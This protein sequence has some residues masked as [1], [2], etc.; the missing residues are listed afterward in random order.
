MNN[1]GKT[2]SKKLLSAA[3]A[4]LCVTAAVPAAAF[5]DD[6]PAYT[7]KDIPA[8]VHA[9]DNVKDLRS[10]FYEDMPNV[11]YV[12]VNDFYSFLL[13]RELS[14]EADGS[15]FTLTN[16]KG[17]K[18]VADADSDTLKTDDLSEFINSASF[19]Q[20][21]I[22]NVYYDGSPFVRVA[23]STT[24]KSAEPAEI[25]FSAYGIDLRADG[26]GLWMPF[27][28][29]NDLFKSAAMLNGYYDGQNYYFVDDNSDF[30]T[31]EIVLD[32]D[33]ASLA[34][35][36]LTEN[37]KR[38]EDVIKLSYS[39][40]C[41]L[42]DTFYGYPGRAVINDTLVECGSLDAAITAMDDKAGGTRTLKQL[43]LSED[44]VDYSAGIYLLEMLFF[45]GGHS[46][47][48]HIYN[49]LLTE[50]L[51]DEETITELCRSTNYDLGNV[52]TL[53]DLD[54]QLDNQIKKARKKQL[55]S[56]SYNKCG[57]TAVYSM[58]TFNPDC[59]AW[60][61]YYEG[62]AGRPDDELA[63]LLDALE[64]ADR[65]EE[66]KNFVLDITCN[67]GGS[68]DMVS[69]VIKLFSGK[70]EMYTFNTLTGQ[71][72]STTYDIDANFDGVFDEKDN[73]KQY[74]L[75][76]GVLSSCQSF[77]CGNLIPA[78]CKEY[79]IPLFGEKSG[80]GACCVVIDQSA[81]GLLFS[82]SA[83]LRL[84]LSDGTNIDRGI[85][86][87]YQMVE[88]AEDGSCDYNKLYDLEFINTK[89]NE[90][91]PEKSDSQPDDSSTLDESSEPQPAEST[92]PENGKNSS[93]PATGTAALG[94]GVLTLAAAAILVVKRSGRQ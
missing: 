93:N 24:D 90:I 91:Y 6:S 15:V 19:L 5:A 50:T 16:P 2:L 61:R 30:N 45:D 53:K 1:I 40:L 84:C 67:P 78:L 48:E 51:T 86:P 74:D 33:V 4:V 68:G 55:G 37:G 29:A 81:E 87:D 13:E 43:L 18:A 75:N 82:Q 9:K 17:V 85:E 10:R 44:L 58:D 34:L 92:V 88:Y 64:K 79:G 63:K 41:F 23:G 36:N 28:I 35:Q 8:Y 31:E 25:D 80:G 21:G 14:A 7:E 76:F 3:A 60:K 70:S 66:V 94:I 77:S 49:S 65:D 22:K 20:E 69:A 39:S 73:E 52:Q 56:D 12:R 71:L 46:S 62:T 72:F 11:P 57:N 32:D 54:E 38:P 47:F 89:M 83:Y 42:I 26:D 27:L 59:A